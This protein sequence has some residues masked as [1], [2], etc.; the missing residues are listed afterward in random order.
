MS[1]TT[2]IVA[3][4]VGFAVTHIVPTSPRLRPRL[5][6]ALG[7]RGYQGVYSLVSFALFVPL[8]WVY[9]ANR[10]AG[11]ELW[12]LQIG[13]DR[14]VGPARPFAPLRFTQERGTGWHRLHRGLTPRAA[15]RRP[16][17]RGE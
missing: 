8:V 2:A 11:P 7:E 12:N 5:I 3:L 6:G 15:R 13:T 9:I 16:T 1:V 17:V 4:W 10:H 14:V